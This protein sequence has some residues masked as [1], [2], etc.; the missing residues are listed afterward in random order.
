MSI[1]DDVDLLLIELS[2]S[3][4]RPQRFAFIEAARLALAGIPNACL[5]PGAA[6]RVLRTLQRNFFDPP[7]D[8]QVGGPRH[9]NRRASKLIAGTAVGA[10]DPREGARDRR[11]LKLVG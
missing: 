5:G 7:P 8:T 11:R 9:Y 10:H 1:P 3:L 2:S 4:P 6:F